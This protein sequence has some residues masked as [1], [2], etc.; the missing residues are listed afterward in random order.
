MGEDGIRGLPFLP[1]VLTAKVDPTRGEGV[2]TAGKKLTMNL[3]AELQ[4][5][6]DARDIEWRI[7]S[8]G[9]KT[10]GS[11]WAKALA[12]LT[13][14]AIMNRLDDTVGPCAWR[15]EFKEWCVG[16]KPGVL[17]GLSIK[18]DGEWITK[19]DGAE[20]TDIESVKGGLSDSQKRAGVQW[21]I[22]RYLYN[23]DETFVECS[24]DRPQ[25]NW[26]YATTKDKLPF[27]WKTP[28]L[29][30]WALPKADNRKPEGN[31]LSD[32]EVDEILGLLK[33]HD[34]EEAR[35]LTWATKAARF[36]V[37]TVN[38]LPRNLFATAKRMILSAEKVPA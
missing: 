23:L 36:D 37:A 35:F 13:N 3:L 33:L 32:G 15:N 9:A 26:N 38:A 28:T 17:C 11:F 20:N 22:G 7:G 21:G 25:G 8:C 24:K 31:T 34:L 27:Y 6:F 12:Y 19:W 30:A 16:G 1:G 2:Y 18:V 10:N 5:P 29:P 14:R 4:K